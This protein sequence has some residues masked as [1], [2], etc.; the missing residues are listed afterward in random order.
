MALVLAVVAAFVLA[1]VAN[2]WWLDVI[3]AVVLVALTVASVLLLL[4]YAGAPDWLGPGEEAEL[5]GAHLVEQETGLPTRRRWN[6]RNAREYAEEV[7]RRGVVAVPGGWRGPDGAHRI[8]LVTTGAISAEELR[9]A[10]SADVA[11]DQLAVLVVVP[12]L[13]ATARQFHRGDPTEAVEHAERVARQT[14]AALNAGGIHSSGHI[15]AADPATAVSDGLRT[16]DA[17]LV[18][19]ARHHEPPLRHLEDVPLEAAARAFGRPM[20]ELELDATRRGG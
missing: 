6:E 13:A 1:A 2:A 18:V 4:H 11:P 12:T 15:G 5:E 20:L 14:V 8:L 19:V 17:E 9:N 10:V 3:A 7:A 16:Y